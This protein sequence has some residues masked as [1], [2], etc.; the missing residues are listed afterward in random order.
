[1]KKKKIICFDIDGTICDTVK[2]KYFEAKPKKKV[3]RTINKLFNE[4]YYIKIFTSR[5]MGRN[6]E[7]FIKAKKQGHSLTKKQLRSW[8]LS[9][10]KLILGKPS[11]DLF[12]DDKNLGYQKNWYLNL[13][14][15]IYL[16]NKD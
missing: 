11:Y 9:Y 2:K 4:G 7:N 10:H 14:K 5:F 1:M 16:L 15:I 3:I 13:K 6:N 12:V 8:G